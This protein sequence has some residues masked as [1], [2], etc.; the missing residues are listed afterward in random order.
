MC[1][2]PVCSAERFAELMLF[3]DYM[4]LA[5]AAEHAADVAAYTSLT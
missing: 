2:V 1:Y 5:D 3:A 4:L